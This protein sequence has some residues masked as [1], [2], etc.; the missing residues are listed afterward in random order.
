MQIEVA[1]C[2]VMTDCVASRATSAGIETARE[3][4]PDKVNVRLLHESYQ[5]VECRTV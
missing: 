3:T 5:G 4:L 1:S 2:G